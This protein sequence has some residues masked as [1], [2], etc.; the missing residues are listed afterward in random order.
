AASSAPPPSEEA[1]AGAPPARSSSS[2]EGAPPSEGSK[3]LQSRVSHKIEPPDIWEQARPPRRFA[4]PKALQRANPVPARG[5]PALGPVAEA[6][7]LVQGVR[8]L[9]WRRPLVETCV[10]ERGPE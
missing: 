8:A 2:S 9:N 5:G 4:D 1:L 7:R 3:R 6:E 10:G